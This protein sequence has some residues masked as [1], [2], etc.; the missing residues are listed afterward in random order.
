MADNCAQLSAEISALRAEIARIPRVDEARI[1]QTTRATL[2][3]EITSAITSAVLAVGSKLQPQIDT[4]KQ[5]LTA[6]INGNHAQVQSLVA[7]AIGGVFSSQFKPAIDAA[8]NVRNSSF[9]DTLRQMKAA[10]GNNEATVKKSAQ[11]AEQALG[12][13]ATF[14]K[15]LTSMN[16]AVADVAATSKVTEAKSVKTLEEAMNAVREAELSKGL[17]SQ[18]IQK[19]ETVAQETAKVAQSVANTSNEIS[20]LRGVVNG[21]G[22]KVN[23]L[24]N[25]IGKLEN[26]VGNALVQSAKAIGISEEALGKIGGFAGKF[27]EIFNVIA[28][29]FTILDGMATRQVLGE[30]IDAVEREIE[31]VNSSVSAILGKLLGLQNRIGGNESLIAQ[32]RNIA[33]DALNIGSKAD[34]TAKNAFVFGVTADAEA[35]QAQLTADGAVRNAA[36]ANENATIA[37]KQGI[38]AEGVGEQAKRIAGD[39]LGKTGVALTT[40]LTAIA[41]YQGIKS[42]RGI[43]G[44]P[45]RQGDR[46]FQGLPGIPGRQGDRGFQG[47]PGIPGRQGERGFQGFPGQNGT[48]G[49]NGVT[50]VIQIPGRD[51]RNGINGTPGRSGRDGTNGMNPAQEASLRALI[52]Q[53]HSQTRANSTLQ[54]TGTR[55]QIQAFIAAAIAPVLFICKQIF[56]LINKAGVV[57]QTALLTIINNKLGN[58]VVGGI[59]GLVTSVAQNTYVEKALSVLTF[60]ATI[61]NALMLS[62]NLAQTLGTIID[63]VLGFILPKGLDGTPISINNVIGKAVHE[64][65]AD[66]IGEANYQEISQDWAKA[67]RIYQ[68][69][70]N[71]FNQIGNAVGLVTAG[72]EVIGGNVA[73]IGN[74]LKIWGVIGEKAYSWMNPQPNLKGKF[75]NFINNATA[76]ANT[77]AMMVAIPIGIS[78]AAVEINSSVGAVKKELTQED[79]KDANGNPVKDSLGNVVKYQPGVTVPDPT[80]TTTAQEQAKADSKN[81]I[82]ATLDDIFDGDD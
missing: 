76:E 25:A 42:L 44:I 50:T 82:A 80:A 43:P 73:K 70:V 81:I 19:S 71:V 1:V 63:Q 17:S 57:A 62:N 28:T 3:P 45:G 38:K 55:A 34:A 61:H 8:V 54:H 69:S 67:N 75:F 41:L 5:Q 4:L 11:D 30:R 18:A 77:I 26:A 6:S 49:T 53:Q 56:D 27:L 23:A 12:K 36:T 21:I 15:T 13:T 47:L 64:I 20:G 14:E 68:A 29:I 32:V 10:I 74:A 66:T 40:A 79:P 31:G 39:A 33:I 59:S 37:Y 60:A 7:I 35:K 78:A 52:I 48:P 72:M 58:Q 65:V 2:Q 24:G 22:G 46:G 51:G 9:A 16:Q